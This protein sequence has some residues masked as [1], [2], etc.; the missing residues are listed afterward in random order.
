MPSSPGGVVGEV[1]KNTRL[2][3][4]KAA[5]DPAFA[6]LWF[7]RE[8]QHPS[9]AN[10]HAPEPGR[11]PHRGDRRQFSVG[12]VKRQQCREVHIRNP[13][14]IGEQEGPRGLQVRFQS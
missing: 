12:A 8:I 10:V 7:F 4:K 13:I 3:H 5:I 2:E 14:A 11:R 6:G 9:L 1:I